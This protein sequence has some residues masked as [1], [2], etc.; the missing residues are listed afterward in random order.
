MGN[1]KAS[2]ILF[3]PIFVCLC[4]LFLSTSSCSR[5]PAGAQST[6]L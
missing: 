3:S 6:V 4:V 1:K 5:R 2:A